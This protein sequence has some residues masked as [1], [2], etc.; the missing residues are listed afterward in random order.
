[1]PGPWITMADLKGVLARELGKEAGD[2]EPRWAG[3]VADANAAAASDIL[4]TML[5]MGYTASQ[6]DLWD[7]A[8]RFNKQLGLY[9][10]LSFGAGLS[11]LSKE[12]IDRHDCRD[13]MRK[14]TFIVSDGVPVSPT[15]GQT[16]IGGITHGRT[17]GGAALDAA[18][19]P[20]ARD[21]WDRGC[22]W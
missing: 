6:V 18:F 17:A 13:Q 9:F 14:Y 21:P 22:R 2:L 12:D 4:T 19:L 15:P 5:G 20:G 8:P 11:G 10:C 16:D 3:V 1:M 7:Q